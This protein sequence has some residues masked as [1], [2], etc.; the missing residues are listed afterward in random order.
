MKSRR[1][2]YRRVFALFAVVGDYSPRRAVCRSPP[3]SSSAPR[4]GRK[5]DMSFRRRCSA[6]DRLVNELV[7]EMACPFFSFFLFLCLCVVQ[8]LSLLHAQQSVP[9]KTFACYWFFKL[10]LI[11]RLVQHFSCHCCT[12]IV[13]SSSLI[14]ASYFLTTP[15]APV[16]TLFERISRFVGPFIFTHR[17]PFQL[18]RHRYKSS[19]VPFW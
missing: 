6:M 9:F 4:D 5:A 1:Q 7:G 19:Q 17:L 10:Y 13:F 3:S 14:K 18:V 11:I 15:L 8:A 2:R 12:F 16:W